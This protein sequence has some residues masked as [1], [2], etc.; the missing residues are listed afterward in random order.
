MILDGIIKELLDAL[1]EGAGF[2]G[3]GVYDILTRLAIIKREPFDPEY[4]PKH[5]AIEFPCEVPEIGAEVWVL[6]EIG[7][8]CTK[9]L[10]GGQIE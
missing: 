10:Q 1:R 4:N 6:T 5:A 3:Y 7:E 8:K 2:D 9:R